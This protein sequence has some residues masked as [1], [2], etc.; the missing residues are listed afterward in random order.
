MQAFKKSNLRS[1][2]I[3]L[4]V[5]IALAGTA[6]SAEKKKTCSKK[7]TA[8]SATSSGIVAKV[9]GTPITQVEL[10]RATKFMLA[11]SKARRS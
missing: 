6:F 5:A 11:Q 9:N 1:I 10:D 2:V 7:T 3:S 4:I 8:A